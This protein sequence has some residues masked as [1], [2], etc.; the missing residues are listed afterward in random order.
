MSNYKRE[1]RLMKKGFM[2][3][4]ICW[5]ALVVLFNIICFVTPNEINGLNKFAGAF[6]SG[7]G[8]IML[9]FVGHLIYDCF[10]LS[11]NNI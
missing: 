2:Y 5:I 8:F 11:T 1:D 7:Y 4:A 6:W 3:Y 9:T 10:A